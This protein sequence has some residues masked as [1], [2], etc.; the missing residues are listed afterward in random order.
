MKQLSKNSLHLMAQI[1]FRLDFSF[2]PSPH[3][4]R[5]TRWT[6]WHQI[7]LAFDLYW[8]F[9]AKETFLLVILKFPLHHQ[10]YRG[11]VSLHWQFIQVA[12]GL[13]FFNGAV[14]STLTTIRLRNGKRNW[15]AHQDAIYQ[16]FAPLRLS[17]LE[18]EKKTRE[19]DSEGN[20]LFPNS[21]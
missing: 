12:V 5:V 18:R 15:D 13:I 3:A 11:V 19:S 8:D 14:D 2:P 6:Y 7:A 16:G 17:T 9:P 10:F 20:S 4:L 1:Q 21:K